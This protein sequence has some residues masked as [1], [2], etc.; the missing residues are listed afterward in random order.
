M[1]SFTPFGVL[2]QSPS[3]T[4]GMENAIHQSEER[5]LEQT[6]QRTAHATSTEVSLSEESDL[7]GNFDTPGGKERVQELART[8]TQ[9]SVKNESGEYINPFSK[10]SPDPEID[11]NSGKFNARKWVKTL[12][13]FTSRDPERYPGRVAGLSCKWSR[14]KRTT[15]L[16]GSIHDLGDTAF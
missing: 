16:L 14:F 10:N 2:P 11:P 1:A 7:D 5:S 9:A 6:D 12:I 15:P 4:E 8:L 3:I 13:G